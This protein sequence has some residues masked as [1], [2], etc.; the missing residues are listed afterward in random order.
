MPINLLYRIRPKTLNEYIDCKRDHNLT[1]E[2]A[3]EN[4]NRAKLVNKNLIDRLQTC[5]KNFPP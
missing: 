2:I 3:V 1:C 4:I 5:T